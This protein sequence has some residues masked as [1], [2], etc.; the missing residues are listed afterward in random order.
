MNFMQFKSIF[1]ICHEYPITGKKFFRCY[2]VRIIIFS[3]KQFIDSSTKGCFRAKFHIKNCVKGE[4]EYDHQI[5]YMK[6]DFS[7]PIF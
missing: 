3:I 5:N 4:W 6:F 7:C 2:E 1:K